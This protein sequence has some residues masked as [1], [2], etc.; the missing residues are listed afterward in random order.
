VAEDT[1]SDIP[2]K[3]VLTG[4]GLTFEKEIDAETA[5]NVMALAMGGAVSSSGAPGGRTRPTRKR[6]RPRAPK[7]EAGEDAKRTRRRSA[8]LGT[9]KDLSLR[10]P[11]KKAFLDFAAEKAPATHQQKQCVILYWLKHEGGLDSGITVDHV[12]TCYLEANWQRPA[13]LDNAISVTAAVKGWIDSS[14]FSGLKLTPRG[15]DMVRHGLPKAKK[16]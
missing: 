9:V 2:I 14:D 12:N 4:N 13:Q 1:Q 8:G 10:P 11:G 15:E 7:A 16:K 6:A 3:L 5:T